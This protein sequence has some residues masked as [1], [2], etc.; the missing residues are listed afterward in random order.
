MKLL[1]LGG[2][3]FVGRHIV[4]AALVRGHEVTI[5]HR[6]KSGAELFPDCEH[7]V[8]DR[9]EDLSALS[10][11]QFDATID[12]SA[13]YPRQVRS[14][15]AAL[16]EGSGRYVL[17]STVSVYDKPLGRGY[18]ESSPLLPAAAEDVTEIT[19]DTYGPLKVTCEFVA[20]E[21]YG[22]N[23]TI[24]RPTYVIGPWDYTRRFTSWVERISAGG[25]VLAPGAPED[26]TQVIDARDMAAWI[27]GLVEDDT[28]GTFHAVGPSST[29]TF[30]ELLGD[31]VAQIA[32]DGTTLTWV[33]SVWLLEQGADD[34]EFPLWS[35][36]D[37]AIDVMT[38][39]PAAA[40]ATGLTL[41]PNQ[42]SVAEIHA[43]ITANPPTEASPRLSDEREAELLAAWHAS[44]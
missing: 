12:V 27:V 7:V 1:V 16:G 25:E 10:S 41:R 14:L 6:G 11:R 17:I 35:G 23:L 5:V 33:D 36:D 43:H 20:R 31:I 15:H 32:P 42:Q 29:Y 38:A 8:A 26:P 34:A 39:D 28:A 19:N 2:T 9:D 24:V 4:E 3:R 30:G 22:D 13:Y 44:R 21:L 37:P 18:D 40:I